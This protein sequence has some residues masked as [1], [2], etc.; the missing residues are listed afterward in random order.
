MLNGQ[1]PELLARAHS[2]LLRPA[3]ARFKTQLCLSISSLPRGA[4]S[5]ASVAALA[6][7]ASR[8]LTVA[9]ATVASASGAT[10][11]QRGLW[12]EA[13]RKGSIRHT[14]STHMHSSVEGPCN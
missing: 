2:R 1:K 10:A 4:A 6:L 14:N 12:E 8:R 3:S 13:A 7:R 9:S 5:A 11:K